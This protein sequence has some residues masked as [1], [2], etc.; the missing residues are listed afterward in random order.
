LR[1]ATYLNLLICGAMRSGTTSLKEYLNEHP[2]I[3]FVDGEDIIIG[4]QFSGYYPFAS[5]SLAQSQWGNDS[6]IYRTVCANLAGKAAYIADKRAYF[7]F[8]PHI[9]LN[10]REQLPHIKLIFILRNP[11]EIVY[12]AFWYGER[13]PENPVTFEEYLAASTAKIH[14]AA[15]SFRRNEWL[16]HFRPGSELPTLVERGIYYPQ[17]IRFYRLFRQEQILVLRFDQ[18]KNPALMMKEVLGFLDLDQDFEFQGLERIHNACSPYPPLETQTR[19]RLQEI[20][21]ESN[22]RLLSFLGWPPSLWD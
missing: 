2:E 16:N 20:Y 3:V 17:I 14:Q 6:Q 5:P 12:S 9:P 4:D 10:L 7:M 11:V 18:L 13:D 21:A 8:F 22:R 1:K 19:A 15:S